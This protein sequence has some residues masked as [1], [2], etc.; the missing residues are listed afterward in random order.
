MAVINKSASLAPGAP[1]KLTNAGQI[2]A[3]GQSLVFTVP[4]RPGRGPFSLAL[5]IVGSPSGLTS[6]ITA[7]LSSGSLGTNLASYVASGPTAAGI[8][9]VPA[10]STTNPIVGGLLFSFNVTALTSGSFD[11]WAVIN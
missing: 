4:V 11:V 1:I 3:S 9:I 6:T 2:N 8:F 5:Q 10:S 7:D